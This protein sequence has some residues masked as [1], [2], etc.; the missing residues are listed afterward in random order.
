MSE[1]TILAR[2]VDARAALIEL[3]PLVHADQPEH[4]DCGSW[5][6]CEAYHDALRAITDTAEIL[7]FSVASFARLSV[8]R[9]AER[10]E[11]RS[12]W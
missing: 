5:G 1:P 6:K 2:L 11:E 3:S 12:P 8:D 4:V 10:I 7:G 9:V